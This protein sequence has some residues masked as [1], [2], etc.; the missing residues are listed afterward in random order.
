MGVGEEAYTVPWAVMVDQDMNCWIN[1]SYPSH[2]HPGGTVQM[3]IRR[4][5]R[6]VDVLHIPSD[7]R[8]RP[9]RDISWVGAEESD[10]LPVES[11]P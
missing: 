2:R 6:G 4:T 5:E 7:H 1:G 3:R 9:S 8:Y 11:F 10:L